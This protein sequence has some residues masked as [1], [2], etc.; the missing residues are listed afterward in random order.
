MKLL[1]I[2]GNS[3]KFRALFSQVTANLENGSCWWSIFDLT[4]KLYFLRRPHL[5]FFVVIRLCLLLAGGAFCTIFLKVPFPLIRFP[6][7]LFLLFRFLQIALLTLAVCL[8]ALLRWL[9][10]RC[11]M[12]YV[13]RNTFT[14]QKKASLYYRKPSRTRT[15][16]NHLTDRCRQ[17]FDNATQQYTD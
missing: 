7:P 9:L 13:T 15:T 10:I 6:T 11:K 5:A 2:G 4:I 12:D 1:S 16:D 8:R 17:P 3:V 14:A